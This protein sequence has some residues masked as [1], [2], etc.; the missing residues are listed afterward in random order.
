[1][2]LNILSIYEKYRTYIVV[3]F[4]ILFILDIIT[5]NILISLALVLIAAW[6]TYYFFRKNMKA[7]A[8]IWAA[9]NVLYFFYKIRIL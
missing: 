8:V 1:M 9:I 7:Q 2:K 4:A 5:A 3:L 6:S